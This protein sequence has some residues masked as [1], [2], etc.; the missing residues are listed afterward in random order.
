MRIVAGLGERA[1]I[2]RGGTDTLSARN[3]GTAKAA[4]SLGALATRGQLA[5]TY[6]SDVQFLIPPDMV[7]AHA[8]APLHQLEAES[9][10]LVGFLLEQRLEE[11]LD[12]R[13]VV[14]MVTRVLIDPADPALTLPSQPSGPVVDTETARRLSASAK[15]LMIPCDDGYRRAVASPEPRGVVESR[16]IALLIEQGFIVVCCGGGGIPVVRGP[17]GTHHGVDAVVEKDLTTAVLA[18]DLGADV[19]LLLTDAA[20]VWADWGTE[21]AKLVRA[22]SPHAL[23][24]LPLERGSMGAKVE[25]AC[26]F[27]HWT[28]HDAFIG[29]V[30]DPV[31]VMEGTSG[32]RIS[33]D[34][35][36]LE[37]ED[38]VIATSPS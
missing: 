31:N 23:R 38:G 37:L 9:E 28:G 4:A 12:R 14:A 1:L 25:A 27:V 19:L 7:Q 15:W 6:G 20:G 32:T 17:S 11:A 22:A 16:A 13:P 36:G 3:L 34:V 30:E 35:A 21:N 24:S 18:R 26:R 29:P 5:V 2:G 33:L 8:F 10:G